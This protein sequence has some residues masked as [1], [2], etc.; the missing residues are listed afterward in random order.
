V[1]APLS[2]LLPA[3]VPVD[4]DAETAREWLLSE[5]GKPPYQ[6]ARP[7][8]FDRVAQGIGDWLDSLRVPDGAGISGLVPLIVVLVVV[9]LIVVAFVVFGRP[10]LNRR[11]RIEPGALFGADDTRSAAELRASAAR[12]ASQG[13]YTLAVEEAFRALARA[14]AERTVVLTA[15]GTTARDFAG[16]A[17]QAFPA[18]GAELAAAAALFDEVRY[19]GAAGSRVQ[20][21]QISALDRQLQGDRP[22]ALERIEQEVVR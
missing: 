8:W 22:A 19:L 20:Y 7:S 18:R 10:R 16:R 11:S 13:D 1:P 15:P 3:S 5:L 4:P 17:A 12:A 21:D 9:A 6:A 2:R 14:L